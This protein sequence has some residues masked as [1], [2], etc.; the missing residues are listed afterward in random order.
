MNTHRIMLTTTVMI[1]ALLLG[2]GPSQ[3]AAYGQG[4]YCAVVSNGTGSVK[5]ICDFD[6]IES[7]TREVVSGNRG[8]CSN[9]PYW[10]GAHGP[11][12]GGYNESARRVPHRTKRRHHS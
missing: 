7:C 1:L 4:R 9:S 8:T 5:E 10:A 6:D 2:S 11:S 3:A 12:W